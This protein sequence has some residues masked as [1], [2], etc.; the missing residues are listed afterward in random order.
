MLRIRAEQIRPF[1]QDAQ[2]AF[3]NRV[4][5]YLRENHPGEIVR[6]RGTQTT[7]RELA[8]A[9]LRLLVEN[10]VARAKSYGMTWKSALISFVVM[11]FIVAPNFDCHAYAAGV[12]RD[13]NIPADRRLEIITEKVTDADWEKFKQSYNEKDWERVVAPAS[14]IGGASK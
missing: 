10:G 1:E 8:E 5:N 9:N 11:M 3:V 4:M 13:E 2:K 6:F 7:V 12:L 14:G